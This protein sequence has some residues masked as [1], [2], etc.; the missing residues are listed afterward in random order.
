MQETKFLSLSKEEGTYGGSIATALIHSASIKARRSI[1]VD[2]DAP[3]LSSYEAD[4][5]SK[6]ETY[7]VTSEESYGERRPGRR[8]PNSAS[9]RDSGLGVLSVTTKYPTVS[10]LLAPLAA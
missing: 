8:K 4:V 2:E 6:S 7:S 5:L 9:S 10:S 3:P 1:L